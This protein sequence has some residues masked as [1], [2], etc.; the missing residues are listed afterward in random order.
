M[1]RN[2][3]PAFRASRATP[4][5][6]G[7]ARMMRRICAFEPLSR[8]LEHLRCVEKVKKVQRRGRRKRLSLRRKERIGDSRRI[9][10]ADEVHQPRGRRFRERRDRADAAEAGAG[11]RVK[12]FRTGPCARICGWMRDLTPKEGSLAE[13]GCAEVPPTRHVQPWAVPAPTPNAPLRKEVEREMDAPEGN[14]VIVE[15]CIH[16]HQAIRWMSLEE[17]NKFEFAPADQELVNRI[18]H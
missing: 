3:V 12:V 8:R 6:P 14:L 17:M 10:R 11:P 15:R 16:E 13:R 7:S 4:S 5:Q 18:F 1:R 2:A 9:A